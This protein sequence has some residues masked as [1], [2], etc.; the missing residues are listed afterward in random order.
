MCR[1]VCSTFYV[2]RSPSWSKM[3][4]RHCYFPQAPVPQFE[5]STPVGVD[6]PHQLLGSAH[7]VIAME[8]TK[9]SSDT[10]RGPA[11][12][13]MNHEK[14]T[15]QEITELGRKELKLEQEWIARFNPPIGQRRP[16]SAS[17]SRAASPA[18]PPA[19]VGGSSTPSRPQ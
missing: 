6:V 18:T 12:N 15:H 17:G 10:R 19:Q 11:Q 5:T 13:F 3:Q 7:N 2:H 14:R 9:G 1:V 4:P 8:P 16:G